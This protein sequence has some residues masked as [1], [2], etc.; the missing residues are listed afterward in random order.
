M[1]TRYRRKS[2]IKWLIFPIVL[3]ALSG[4]FVWQ[5]GEGTYGTRSAA[6][7]ADELA[8]LEAEYRALVA[9]REALEARVA[10]LRPSAL[11]ADLLDERARAKLDLARTDEIVLFHGAYGAPR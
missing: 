6:E 10:R 5:A 3:M 7:L 1:P 9:R 2:P 4:Y 8:V 11:D